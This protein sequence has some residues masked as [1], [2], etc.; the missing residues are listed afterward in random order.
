[1]TV[2]ALNAQTS[3]TSTLGT[4][5]IRRSITRV[6]G[7]VQVA[8]LLIGGIIAIFAASA[9]PGQQIVV[10]TLI[11]ISYACAWNLIG[12]F[13]GQ[14]AFG[15][16]AFFGIGAFTTTLL[17]IHASI[18]P[19]FGMLIGAVLAAVVAAVIGVITLR[20][21]GL[22][23]GLVTVVFPVVFSVFATYLGFQEV[24]VSF[25]PDGGLEYF[26]PGD[27]RVLGLVALVV[28]VVVAL[29]TVRLA[30][31]RVGLYWSAMRSDQD[32]AEASGVATA[33]AKVGALALSAAFSAIAGALYA[34]AVVV[35]TPADV[36]ALTMSVQPILFSVF[37]GVGLLAGP[38]I[39]AALLV[40]LSQLLS[41]HFGSSL[42]ALSGL[43]YGV[44]LLAVI[45]LIPT[46]VL[47]ALRTLAS[48]IWRRSPARVKQHATRLI[49]TRDVSAVSD[50]A[51]SAPTELTRQPAG[52]EVLEIGHIRKSFGGTQV[53]R[54]VTFSVRAGEI[55]GVI[56]PNGA[57][58]TTLFNM[59]SG[60]L[61]SDGGVVTLDGKKLTGQRPYRIARRGIGRT[62]QTVRPFLGLSL[63]ENVLVPAFI[64][65]HDRTA[66]TAAVWAALHE[67]ELLDRAAMPASSL[68]TGE[69][70]RLE[71]ARAI[72]GG[73]RLLLL[74]EF[75]GGLSGTDATVLLNAIT[76]WTA[77]GGSVM[78]I[79]HTMR[80]MVGFVDRFVVLNYGEVIAQG[81]SQEISDDHN[82]IEAYL[83]E[84]WA[85][86]ARS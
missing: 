49:R 73:A 41:L 64:A 4:R 57:G 3:S 43:L 58:K 68:T 8:L 69:L 16:S 76:R 61:E 9:G 65:H 38:I 31:S 28:A 30:R 83:G 26:T 6:S 70:R 20:L 23:F 35:V 47:P 5:A 59:V 44:V 33:Q 77:N 46:G 15:H 45:V 60:F 22:Y 39:G 13:A 2:P 52:A 48:A 72:A 18:P 86:S 74:D 53:L 75:L 81:T 1:M 42:P 10:L 12:G 11:F 17:T 78:A 67:V 79:E 66:A 27:P 19:L 51:S 14:F 36:F 7:S 25:H 55:V 71:L 32:A 24:P 82:V 85:K 62:F 84:R 56:G 54:D 40:P 34:S 50:E 21:R 63:A 37:G 29:V 80:A